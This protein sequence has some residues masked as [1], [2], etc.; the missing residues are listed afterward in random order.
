MFENFLDPIKGWWDWNC[1]NYVAKKAS[2]ISWDI[3]AGRVVS[4]NASGA[5]T[6]GIASSAMGMFLFQGSDA[7]DVTPPSGTTAAGTYVSTP[8][9]PDGAMMAL[10]ATGAYELSTTA[11][12][13]SKTYAPNQYLTA[14]ADDATSTVGGVLTN[15][16]NVGND[17]IRPYQD[18]IC[19]VVSKGRSANEYGVPTLEFWT[20]YMPG[21]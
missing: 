8:I 21:L 2:T 18:P 13:R 9:L 10:V 20:V 17:P 11:F 6:T 5:F 14:I 3:P 1:V 15:V 4:L 12:D 19:G 7:L 16:R